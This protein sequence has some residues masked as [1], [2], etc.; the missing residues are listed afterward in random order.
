MYALHAY[1]E[2]RKYIH[3]S[4]YNEWWGREFEPDTGRVIQYPTC[5][6]EKALPGNKGGEFYEA[7]ADPEECR[8]FWTIDG[9]NTAATGG[10]WSNDIDYTYDWYNLDTSDPDNHVK[11][12]MYSV[13][14]DP[15]N[16]TDPYYGGT[17]G[18]G[19][20][21]G[22]LFY[23]I[24]NSATALGDMAS[25]R[26]SVEK[27]MRFWATTVELD[28]ILRNDSASAAA[29]AFAAAALKYYGETA[30]ETSMALRRITGAF[31][32]SITADDAK[33]F[34]LP[35]TY[36]NPEGV[37]APEH[38]D[39][40]LNAIN[41]YNAEGTMSA[42][43]DTYPG[44]PAELTLDVLGVDHLYKAAL[45]PLVENMIPKSAGSWGNMYMDP[46]GTIAPVDN[47]LWAAA[48]A[49]VDAALDVAQFAAAAGNNNK[50]LVCNSAN[51]GLAPEFAG[52]KSGLNDYSSDGADWVAQLTQTFNARLKSVLDAKQADL[53]SNPNAD[54]IEVY[55]LFSWSVTAFEDAKYL[56]YNASLP[57]FVRDDAANP[58]KRVLADA[59]MVAD[60]AV[61]TY[62][63]PVDSGIF[64]IDADSS[65]WCDSLHTSAK[66]NEFIAHSMMSSAQLLMGPDG[67]NDGHIDPDASHTWTQYGMEWINLLLTETIHFDGQN[68]G[69]DQDTFVEGRARMSAE[70]KMVLFGL[71]LRVGLACT[72]DHCALLKGWMLKAGLGGGYFNEPSQL[73]NE[74]STRWNINL[75]WMETFRFALPKGG[76]PVDTAQY[77]WTELGQELM[78]TNRSN[79]WHQYPK[80]D[81][82]V[83]DEFSIEYLPFFSDEQFF[84]GDPIIHGVGTEGTWNRDVFVPAGTDGDQMN[85]AMMEILGFLT[86][87]TRYAWTAKGATF[88]TSLLDG[89]VGAP[90]INVGGKCTSA[91]LGAIN[92]L[93]ASGL[94]SN[95]GI[96]SAFTLDSMFALGFTEL[97][98]S[99]TLNERERLYRTN[100]VER[101]IF[102]DPGPAIDTLVNKD[103]A[104]VYYLTASG[105]AKFGVGQENDELSAALLGVIGPLAVAEYNSLAETADVTGKFLEHIG[106][107]TRIDPNADYTFTSLGVSYLNKAWV[108]A[109][110]LQ[111]VGWRAWNIDVLEG[112]QAQ[113]SVMNYLPGM[114]FDAV[115]FNDDTTTLGKL[116]K[117][118]GD[119]HT[120]DHIGD[121]NLSD[122]D[123]T[124]YTAPDGTFY[125]AGRG[126]Q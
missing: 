102:P 15:L 113:L 13:D 75:E 41:A 34:A 22:T 109:D 40:F 104:V 42:A 114:E 67:A 63:D 101:Y 12:N 32:S 88:M 126:I 18:E 62:E 53:N 108:F 97:T 49:L 29:K 116:V 57:A 25:K 84:Q 87:K 64:Y 123:L 58:M 50:V 100:N 8:L 124:E 28:S 43:V 44:F 103:P 23:R 65:I 3:Y 36:L 39:L 2:G 83:G 45:T 38:A 11:V 119:M 68:N 14:I 89:I 115:E 82:E 51:I 1:S 92:G 110:D 6:I 111:G 105:V 5:T 95:D 86:S 16:D 61:H 59:D 78:A 80:N 77:F 20:N 120:Y 46:A 70:D 4:L 27:Q 81:I 79:V 31:P 47:T 76:Y 73:R 56:G 9:L 85:P 10:Y 125:P 55:D 21:T 66:A 93:D 37:G 69:H 91:V 90:T 106:A 60:K 48:A 96:D 19:F 117:I 122:T 99:H 112:F 54:K 17:N 7:G 98:E 107:V 52:H 30:V 24:E 26:D 71:N 118:V 33:N 74:F 94:P 121:P 35:L 72:E